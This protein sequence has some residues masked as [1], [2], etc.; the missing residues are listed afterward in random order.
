MR[1]TL[2][3]TVFRVRP[4]ALAFALVCA[5]SAPGAA[6]AHAARGITLKGSDTMVILAQRWAET[7]MK[8]NRGKIVQVT[9]GG[10][11][12]GIAALINGTTDICMAS[13]EMK[14]AEKTKLR[15]RFQTMGVE[16]PVARDGL[17]VYVHASNPV[18]SIDLDQLRRIYVG[19]ITNW[20]DVGG[21]DQPIT[22]YGRENSS[23]TYVFFKDHILKG[24]DF[25]PRTQTLPGTAAVVNAVAQ[26]THGIGYG[27]AAYAKGVRDLALSFGPG[28]PA[29]LPSAPTVADGS[30][31]LSRYLYFYVRNK[32]AGDVR[33]FIDWVVSAEGQALATKVGYFPLK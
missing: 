21:A 31:P 28:K 26:D 33:L 10:S 29:V 24:K 4:L 18:K 23:G 1:S 5:L 27:G 9:G 14:N 11:G 30:Y 8:A 17:A 32:P 7:Y 16:I 20:K 25:S 19:E 12:T 6:P 3:S 2:R 22:V 13:R 15:D